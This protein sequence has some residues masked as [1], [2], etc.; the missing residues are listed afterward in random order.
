MRS[1]TSCS[2]QDTIVYAA[3]SSRYSDAG[4]GC[5]H[6][7]SGPGSAE[8]RRARSYGRPPA[9]P[10]RRAT[11]MVLRAAGRVSLRA[12]T[13]EEGTR[14]NACCPSKGMAARAARTRRTRA[15]RSGWRHI[16]QARKRCCTVG[17]TRPGEGEDRALYGRCGRAGG[18]VQVRGRYSFN[19]FRDG[20]RATTRAKVESTM[21]DMAVRRGKRACWLGMW[22]AADDEVTSGVFWDG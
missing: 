3:F 16:L 15:A 18:G 21:M 9:R 13:D 4:K 22:K 10:Q 2:P 5:T 7:R 8:R 19:W 17:A 6:R 20:A 12:M 1:R 14:Q 11:H